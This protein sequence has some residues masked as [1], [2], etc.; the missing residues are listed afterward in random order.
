MDYLWI[1][2]FKMM[3]E[4][5]YIYI[6]MDYHDIDFILSIHVSMSFWINDIIWFT[7]I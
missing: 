4:Y 2:F 6:L 1:M 7:L 3:I 5:D